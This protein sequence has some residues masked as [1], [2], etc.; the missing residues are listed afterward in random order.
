MKK[1][2]LAGIISFSSVAAFADQPLSVQQGI[3]ATL[4]TSP[5]YISDA[6]NGNENKFS[7][8]FGYAGNKIDSNGYARLNGFEVGA[9]YDIN[10]WGVWT[11]FEKQEDGDA[12]FNQFA[13]GAHYKFYN[14]NNAYVLGATGLGYANLK[15]DEVDGADTYKIKGDYLYIPAT[16]EAGYMFT[17]NFGAYASLGYKWYFN[18]DYKVYENG[19]KVAD[20]KSSSSDLHGVSY[21]FGVRV[22]F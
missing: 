3:P 22:A 14:Q 18:N 17:P 11:E 20:G 8:K 9:A 15:I 13:V 5:N 7:L 1:I 4:G 10:N 12:D 21:G 6:S 2:F 16:V 19:V